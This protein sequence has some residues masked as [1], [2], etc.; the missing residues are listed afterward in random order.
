MSPGRTL[1]KTIYRHTQDN[2]PETI[3]NGN[4]ITIK[5]ETDPC[6]TAVLLGSLTL[7]QVVLGI[8][9]LRKHSII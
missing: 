4:P 1:S 2:W 6:G 9:H 3:P 8:P 5:P 7:L